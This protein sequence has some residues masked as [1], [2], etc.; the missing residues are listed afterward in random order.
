[1]DSADDQSGDVCDIGQ[2]IRADLLGNLAKRLEIDES[3][4]RGGSRHNDAGFFLAREVADQIVID[5]MG[6]AIHAVGRRLPE[7]AGNTRIPSVGKM[8]AMRER[9]AHNGLARFQQ[10]GVNGEI[11]G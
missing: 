8:S 10:P 7:G 4:I 2:K 3:R 5:A 11:G 9:E 6:F 1:M